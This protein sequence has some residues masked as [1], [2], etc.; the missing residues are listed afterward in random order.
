[1]GVKGGRRKVKLE[2]V[3]GLRLTREMVVLAPEMGTYREWAVGDQD[4]VRFVHVELSCWWEIQ[5]ADEN[6]AQ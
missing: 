6:A 2:L 5:V 3:E 4:I 1:M